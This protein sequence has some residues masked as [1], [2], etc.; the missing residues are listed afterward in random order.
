[1]NSE[2][3]IEEAKKNDIALLVYGSPLVATTHIS[4][5]LK[6]KKENI[7]Y[8]IINSASVVDAIAETG[9][10]LYKFGRTA[11]MPAWKQGYKPMSFV[12][13]INENSRAGALT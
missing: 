3:I 5:I 4:L 2:Q 8:K 10:Q 7:P 1:V 13:I 9:L 12:N 6:C 11:S